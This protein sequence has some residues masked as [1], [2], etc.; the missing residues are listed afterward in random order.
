MPFFNQRGLE[1]HPDQLELPFPQKPITVINGS[2]SSDMEPLTWA[3]DVPIYT[4]EQLNEYIEE[5]RKA[6]YTSL[7]DAPLMG[8]KH[9]NFGAMDNCKWGEDLLSSKDTML[10]S[11][12][13]NRTA[14]DAWLASQEEWDPQF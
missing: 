5:L 10:P 8:G 2:G 3:G 14:H 12:Y 6:S 11:Q 1:R 9:H 4:R 13:L 7:D